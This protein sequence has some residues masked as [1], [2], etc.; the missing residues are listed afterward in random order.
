MDVGSEKSVTDLFICSLLLALLKAHSLP[1]SLQGVWLGLQWQRSAGLGKQCQ[2][3]DPC[4]SG[5]FAQRV[6][7]PGMCGRLLAA[8]LHLASLL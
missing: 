3:A 1:F 7:E 6:R 5:S 8:G 2:S 4:A